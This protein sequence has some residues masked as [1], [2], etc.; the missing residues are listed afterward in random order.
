MSIRVTRAGLLTTVQ[1]LGRHARAFGVVRG[2]AMDRRAARVANLLVGNAAG[3]ALLEATLTGPTLTF[4]EE[5]IVAITGAEPDAQL[6]GVRVA[7]WRPFIARPGSVLELG[8]T[9]RG[10]RACIA[11]GGGI[12]VPVVLGSRGT[13]LIARMGGLEGRALAAGDELR[14]RPAGEAT[15]RRMRGLRDAPPVRWGAGR[16]LRDYVADAAM[17][18]VIDGPEYDAFTASSHQAFGAAPFAVTAQSNRMGYRLSGA[19][20]ELKA[21]LEMISSPVA[22]GTVQVPPTGQPIVL[23]ADAQTVGGYPRIANVITADLPALAQL[24]PGGIVRFRRIDLEDAQRIQAAA[25]RDL[26]LFSV[27]LTLQ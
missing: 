7:A 5:A 11:V 4:T 25:E 18:R 19:L 20:L 24:A 17:V 14:V 21:P 26:A 1:D 9:R 3:D 10:C 16:S 2:G 12:D 27:A 15:R 13:D 8:G 23:M 6:D 22:V